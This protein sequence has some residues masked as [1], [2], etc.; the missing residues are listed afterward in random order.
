M[1]GNCDIKIPVKDSIS[2]SHP[3]GAHPTSC[4]ADSEGALIEGLRQRNPQACERLVREYGTALFRVSR[5]Y[6]TSDSDARDAL[7][8]AFLNIWKG[9]D[10]FSG[11]SSFYAWLH[12]IAVNAALMRLRT[13]R[14]RSERSIDELLPRYKEDGH[15]VTDTQPWRHSA[16]SE[17][18][19]V[20]TRIQVRA[21][22]DELPEPH[23]TVL[24]LRD[25]EEL[26]TAETA[27]LLG[28]QEGT[29]KVRLHRARQALRALLEP[30]F[31]ESQDA[32]LIKPDAG[33]CLSDQVRSKKP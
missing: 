32:G 12:R 22:I 18:E 26:D 11:Q 1:C 29:V 30:L 28:I 8:E 20:R 33:N 21:A 15:Q 7:Q 2:G 16:E 4:A 23:R 25:I 10:Q 19:D 9:I 14:R 27:R 5:R 24:L 17:L 31:I 3:T 13:Q 6:L